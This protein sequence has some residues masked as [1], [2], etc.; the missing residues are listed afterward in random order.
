MK[1]VLLTTLVLAAAS[2]ASAQTPT[3]TTRA[4]GSLTLIGGWDFNG[5]GTATSTSSLV[6]R[7][8]QQYSPYFA[9]GSNGNGNAALT[10]KL[11]LTSASGAGA[12]FSSARAF[13]VTNAPVYDLLSTDGLQVSNNSLG[14]QTTATRSLLLSTTGVL[15]NARAVFEVSTL[16]LNNT[17]SDINVAYSARNQGSAAAAISWSYSLDGGST[18]TPIAGSSTAFAASQASFAVYTA[19]FSSVAALE[20]VSSLLIGLDYSETAAGASVFLDNVAIYGTAFAS[21][22]PEPSSFAALAGLAGLGLA[23]SRRRRA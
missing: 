12:T 7:Y 17:F 13:D 5:V 22:I 10:A 15:N 18:F 1:K 3:L 20:G 21:P 4:D 16:N 8:N 19:D 23:A 9:S 11:Y 14:D 6:A 2:A